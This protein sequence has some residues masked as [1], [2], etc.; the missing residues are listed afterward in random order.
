[1]RY[2]I[3]LVENI[4]NQFNS[5]NPQHRNQLWLT[6]HHQDYWL[7]KRRIAENRKKEKKN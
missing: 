2:N 5:N 1:M 7:F 4:L 6:K 3:F